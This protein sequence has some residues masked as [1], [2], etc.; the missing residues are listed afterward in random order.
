ML[1][2]TK[3]GRYLISYAVVVGVC[4][5]TLRDWVSFV[6]DEDLCGQNVFIL[7]I[8]AT[9]M[10]SIN[11]VPMYT[12]AWASTT[13]TRRCGYEFNSLPHLS[14]ITVSRKRHLGD[15]VYGQHSLAQQIQ[16]TK[17]REGDYEHSA[18]NLPFLKG[19][20]DFLSENKCIHTTF[21]LS[22]AV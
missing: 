3:P 15:G 8:V 10:L 13:S 20:S 12:V 1:H 5:V 16:L 9:Y 22:N 21:T 18:D 6:T 4:M 19:T 14:V 7:F 17:V 11:Q 2:R